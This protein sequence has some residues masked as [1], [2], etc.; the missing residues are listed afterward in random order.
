MGLAKSHSNPDPLKRRPSKMYG[1]SELYMK[2]DAIV[3]AVYCDLVNG[4]SK[5]SIL[6]KLQ[7]G[8]YS[9]KTM[10]IKTAYDYFNAALNRISY[11]KI[12]KENELREMLYARLEEVYRSCMEIGNHMTAISALKEMKDLFIPKQPT[13]AVQVNNQGDGKVEVKFGF[14]SDNLENSE[15]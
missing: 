1:H 11:D 13:T 3:D 2:V 10:N 9:D 15:I 5:S 12:E 4:E 7:L 6:Q 14:S 8:E